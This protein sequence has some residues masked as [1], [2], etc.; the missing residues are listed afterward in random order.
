MKLEIHVSQL[1][2]E[3]MNNTWHENSNLLEKWASSQT[4]TACDLNKLCIFKA[5]ESYQT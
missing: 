5:K 4:Q 1:T 3:Q 2:Q